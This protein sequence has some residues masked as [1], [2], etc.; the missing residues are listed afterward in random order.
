MQRAPKG[1]LV[2]ATMPSELWR[3]PGDGLAHSQTFLCQSG[4]T[5]AWSPA[6]CYMT[7]VAHARPERGVYQWERLEG[8]RGHTGDSEVISP[9]SEELQS[10][11]EKNRAFIKN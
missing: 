7:A 5:L 6:L 2:P 3:L 4:F 1:K 8:S 11:V 10:I 9:P